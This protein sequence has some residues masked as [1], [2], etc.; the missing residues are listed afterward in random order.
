MIGRTLDDRYVI[1]RL[2]GQ[3]GMGAVYEARHAGTGRRVAVKIIL[4]AGAQNEDHVARFQREARAV[5]AAESDYIAQV[6]DTGRDRESGAPYIAMEFLEGEDVQALLDRLGPLPVD[7][8]LR[9]AL[10]ACLG[11]E[12]AHAAGVIHRDIKPANLFLSRKEQG[13]RVV[14]LLDFGVAK[15]AAPGAEDHGLTKTGAMIG[16]P[17]YMSPEQ[18]RASG[19]IDARSDLWSLGITLF[20]CISGR[21]PNDGVQGLGELLLTL[22]S[23]PAPWLQTVA[24]WVP[25]EVAQVVRR[26]LTIDPA[27]RYGSAS[28]LAGSLRAL[29]PY[30]HAI[31]DLML[32]PLG[33]TT[34]SF[35]APQPQP[36][37]QQAQSQPQALAVSAAVSP[38]TLGT[39]G[40]DPR[41]VAPA[42][43]RSIALVAGGA[44]GL[45]LFGVGGFLL[46]RAPG[47]PVTTP[48][49]GGASV[50][51]VAAPPVSAATTAS[52]L[53]SAAPEPSVVAAPVPVPAVVTGAPSAKRAV[54]AP[55]KKVKS[56]DE[57]S[58]K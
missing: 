33:A 21:R 48:A 1:E 13:A 5:G 52:P 41:A 3:G 40:H 20:Q 4:G 15:I 29:L 56:D 11:L 18:A 43:R 25:A 47:A 42:Q 30:G 51:A 24:P 57:S 54:V 58:R 26:A 37:P 22:C 16:S 28:E 31:V 45:L 34:R 39:T 36:A 50:V 23:T 55:I 53:A 38:I 32:V 14:K 7:L 10:Q 6:F 19:A 8:A 35:T 27:A 46:A 2:L 12:R 49:A 44:A 17:L 9:I